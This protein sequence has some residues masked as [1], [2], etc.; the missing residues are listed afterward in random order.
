M[1]KSNP[2]ADRRSENFIGKIEGCENDT[3]TV[4]FDGKTVQ[5][6]LGNIDKARLRPEFKF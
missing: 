5:I 2:P 4:S 6:E 3:V 1:P